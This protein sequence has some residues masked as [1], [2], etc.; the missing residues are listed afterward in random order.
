M[1]LPKP[2]SISAITG[3]GEAAAMARIM[4]RCCTGDRMLASGTAWL[5]DS[6]K[7]LPQ[8]ASKRPRRPTGPTAGC[9]PTWHEPARGRSADDGN[10]RCGWE[11]IG[12]GAD[13]LRDPARCAPAVPHRS[14]W[15]LAAQRL[16]R[17]RRL[18]RA[19]PG[20]YRHIIGDEPRR[21]RQQL[22]F[23]AADMAGIGLGEFCACAGVRLAGMP[24]AIS[25]SAPRSGSHS[26]A[27]RRWSAFSPCTN[28]CRQTASEPAM[29]S[30][31]AGNRSSSSSSW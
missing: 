20:R 16:R 22:V 11:R 26:A 15:R 30:I 21:Q 8:T 4:S 6:S 28:A 18:A 7:P 14:A 27:S 12:H 31:S 29:A 17:R 24:A 25:A 10:G 19:W 1:A 23:L 13:S 2:V 5:A 3:A 9:A